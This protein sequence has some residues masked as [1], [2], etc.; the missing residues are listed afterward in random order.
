MRR[1]QQVEQR[2]DDGLLVVDL[3]GRQVLTVGEVARGLMS[4]LLVQL[5]RLRRSS[6]CHQRL[7]QVADHPTEL[8]G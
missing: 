7:D 3:V 6:G 4:Q 5:I 2:G 8:E 1:E